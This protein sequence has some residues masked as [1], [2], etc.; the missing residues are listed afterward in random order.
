LAAN[1]QVAAGL[2]IQRMPL[3]GTGNLGQ[4]NEDGI[5]LDEAFN[6]IALFAQSLK[7]EELLELDADTILHRL[8]W[9]DKLLRFE[10]QTPKFAC[11]CSREKVS[12]MLRGLGVAEVESIL[13]E[14]D[15]IEVGCDFCGQQYHFDAVDA[16]KIFTQALDQIPGPHSVQ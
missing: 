2:L 13:S 7:R 14:R 1:G 15:K 4:A 16:A 3:E 10:P 11:S 12:G 8:F 6:R 9:E 5:G